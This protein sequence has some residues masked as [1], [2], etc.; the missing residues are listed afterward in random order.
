M[1][2]LDYLSQRLQLTTI[3]RNRLVY[4]CPPLLSVSLE[5]NIIPSLDAV[6]QRLQM[7]DEELRT[8]VLALPQAIKASPPPP[9]SEPPA[10]LPLSHL[11]H[12]HHPS[13]NPYHPTHSPSHAAPAPHRLHSSTTTP[14]QTFY[15]DKVAMVALPAVCFPRS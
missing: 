13:P 2:K 8:I 5:H 11:L 9:L 1:P 4:R 6:Q 12:S 14:L 3:E 10:S 15:V 7:S